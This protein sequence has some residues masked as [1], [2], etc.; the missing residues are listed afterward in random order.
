MDIEWLK[1]FRSIC[2]KGSN[3]LKWQLPEEWIHAELFTYFYTNQN[4]SGKQ[5][6][7]IEQETK[8]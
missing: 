5:N 7:F 3:T 6:A 4:T 8:I 2:L 1:V